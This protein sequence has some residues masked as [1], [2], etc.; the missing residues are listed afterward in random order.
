M[1]TWNVRSMVD[2]EGPVEIASQRADSH[3]GEDRKVDLV[4]NELK[5]Y[6]VKVAALQ[7]TKWFG[8]DTYQVNGSVVLTAGRNTPTEG[9]SVV[10]GEGVALVLLGPAVDAWKKGGS[11]WS[12]W[13]SRAVSARLQV[14]RGAAGR[15]HVVSCYAPTRAASRET[16]DAFFQELEN[17]LSTVP[18]GEK[19]LLMGDFNARVGSRECAVGDM[20]D[21]VRGPYGYGV[22]NDAGKELLSFLAV[23][24]ATVC[25]T[26]YMKRDIHK[27]TWQH[28]KSKQWSCI[29]F[30]ITRQ[31]DRKMCTDV[32]VRRGAECNTDH[33]LLCI[34]LKLK[35]EGCRTSVPKVDSRRY[36]VSS[37][38]CAEAGRAEDNEKKMVFVEQVLEKASEDWPVEG[39]V[40]EKWSVVCSALTEAAD[41]VLG[42]VRNSQPD[43][44]RES[45]EELK[46][47]LQHR[48]DAY[49][50]WLNSKKSVDLSRFKEARNASRRAVRNTKNRWFQEKAEEAERER[51]GG[52]KVWKCIRDMQRGRRGLRPS[53]EVNIH[54]EDGEPCKTTDA[55]HQRWRQHFNSVLNIRTRFA[56]T[57]MDRVRQREVKADLA[58][59]PSLLEI[60]RALG[61]LKN[62][63]AAGISGILPEMLKAG[64]KN[65][66]FVGMIMD[67]V[68]ST[69]E[70]KCVPQEWVDAVLIPIPKKGNLHR[71]DSWRGIAL[72]EV[73]GKVVAR[74]I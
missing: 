61:Q 48:N 58:N 23:H 17:I 29:D 50:R 11:Q 26:W 10:R 13:S 63:K 16:K 4:V 33:Q 15:L 22:V 47:L 40:Q 24:Q 52:K 18:Q 2:T 53:R 1:A 32:S 67:L 74:I 72:L 62:G 34:T 43:W 60:T 57:E 64:R 51:F 54:N 73:V 19:Y 36:D 12:A 56:A 45:M 35:R 42:R 46:P 7:E 5:R 59:T 41:D 6:D 68:R 44:F 70:E 14:G 3:R 39:S 9:E 31:K 65:K 69:W 55:Q 30:A 28:P 21:G 38:A 8:C 49:R 66:E 20:W 25:N 37:L 27:Q 71:C